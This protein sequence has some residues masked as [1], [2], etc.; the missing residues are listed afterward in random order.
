MKTYRFRANGAYMHVYTS[1]PGDAIR[2][3]H[4]QFVAAGRPCD[5]DDIVLESVE[6]NED[7]PR[8]YVWED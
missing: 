5:L 3:A 4:R 1:H 2:L 8:N 6:D 7:L